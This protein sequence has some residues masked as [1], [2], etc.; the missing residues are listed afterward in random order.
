MSQQFFSQDDINNGRF[1]VPQGALTTPSPYGVGVRAPNAQYASMYGN[2][3]PA[4]PA[5]AP[6]T[7]SNPS[8]SLKLQ[9]YLNYITG[10]ANNALNGGLL[11]YIPSALR[12]G[13]VGNQA[14]QTF[15]A[16]TASAGMSSYSGLFGGFGQRPW[17]KG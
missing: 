16:P 7:S 10:Q 14:P 13:Q 1:Y 15:N 5:P 4:A 6:A 11:G 2:Q 3:Q 9:Q 8:A 12:A 17:M